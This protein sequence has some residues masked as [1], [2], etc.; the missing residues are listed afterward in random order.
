MLT[1]DYTPEQLAKVAAY[2]KEK[3]NVKQ[4][5]TAVAANYAICNGSYQDNA[6]PVRHKRT[7]HHVKT[8][9]PDASKTT[10]GCGLETISLCYLQ[11]V[12]P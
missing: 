2:T 7:K 10:R 9:G 4:R 8:E 12:V 11:S 3:N 6:S 5:Q 1:A